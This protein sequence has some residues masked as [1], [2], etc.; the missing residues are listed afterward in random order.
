MAIKLSPHA[1]KVL[2]QK[3]RDNIA[4]LNPAP[5]FLEQTE[6]Y[7]IPET[8]LEFAADERAAIIQFD[9]GPDGPLVEMVRDVFE[10]TLH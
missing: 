7:P 9:G 8:E 1:V 10:G 2:G 5:S 6:G 4:A 3:T